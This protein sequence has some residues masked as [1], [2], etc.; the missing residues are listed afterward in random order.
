ME[1]RVDSQYVYKHMDGLAG[2]GILLSVYYDSL[3]IDASLPQD[4]INGLYVGFSCTLLKPSTR[5]F[6]SKA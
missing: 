2:L 5:F 1:L 6:C 3:H 4:F